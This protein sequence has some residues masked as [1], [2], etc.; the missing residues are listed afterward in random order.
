MGWDEVSNIENLEELFK[1]VRI[2]PHLVMN[3]LAEIYI[4]NNL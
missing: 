4:K 2:Y 1:D 3:E